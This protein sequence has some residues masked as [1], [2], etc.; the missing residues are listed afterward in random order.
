MTP[1]EGVGNLPTLRRTCSRSLLWMSSH[2]PSVIAEGSEVVVDAGVVAEVF[3]Q[4]PPGTAGATEVEDG[5][6]HL[7]HVE[8]AG[9][10]A[11][12]GLGD[13]RGDERPLLIGQVRGVR[14]PCHVLSIEQ[15]AAFL[16]AF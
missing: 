14:R 15:E 3:G 1:A 8:A 9:S 16:Y 6:D 11:G 2:V 4:H 13:Q 12:D 7:P 5:V 10:A